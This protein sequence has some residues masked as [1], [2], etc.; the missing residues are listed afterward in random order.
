[1]T[2]RM[3]RDYVEQV[4]PIFAVAVGLALWAYL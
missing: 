3:G 4:A 1:V 2:S